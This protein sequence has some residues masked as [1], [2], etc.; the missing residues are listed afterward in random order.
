MG[1][2]TSSNSD[3]DGNQPDK[4]SEEKCAESSPHVKEISNIWKVFMFRKNLGTGASCQVCL[5]K[6]RETNVEYALKML[7]FKYEKLFRKE[8]DTL[9]T[10]DCP[11][12]VRIEGGYR[13][14]RMQYICM[15]YC[16]GK[17]LFDRLSKEK[18]YNEGVAANCAKEMLQ[19]VKYLHDLD[20]VHRDIK[21]T[22]FVF[23]TENSYAG[24][25]LLDF[26]LAKPVNPHEV[27]RYRSGTPYF[28]APELIQNRVKRS[29]DVCKASD[30]WAL[31]V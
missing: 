11:N 26:G 23:L 18:K 27:Y 14:K 7:D 29:A 8:L 13:D 22:N 5:V 25:K 21:P 17:S 3:S 9:L 28:M 16:S 20:I 30:M 19:A 1:C 2:H 10:M 6:K 24:L 12:I 4:K 31:G 15:E